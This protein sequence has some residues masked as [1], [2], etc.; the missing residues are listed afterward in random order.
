VPEASRANVV[1]S[2]TLV[3]GAMIEETYAVFSAWDF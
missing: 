1:S 3:K 2:F